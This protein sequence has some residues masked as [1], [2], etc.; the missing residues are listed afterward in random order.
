[1]LRDFVEALVPLR[2][3]EFERAIAGPAERVG[4]RFEPGLLTELV[5]DVSDE[6][7]AL[8]LLQYALTELYERREGTTL[9]RDAYRAIGGVSGALAGRAEEIYGGLGEQA[10]EAGRQLFLRLVTLGEGAEDTRRRVERA[11]LVSME[12]DQDALADAIQ[13]FG[14]WRLLSFDRD[15]RTGT[16]TVEVAHEALMREWGRFRR[17]VDSGREE[18]RLHRRLA[19]AAREWQEAQR[20]PSYLLRGSNLAQFEPL[21]G[22]ATIALTGLEREFVDASR[23]ANELELARQRRQNRRLRMLLAGAVV[24]LVLAVVAGGLALVSRSNAQHEARVALGRQL[25][26]EAVSEPRIDLATLLARESLN[27][28]R[29]F[30]TK[31]TLLAT[32]LRTPAVIGTFT[33]PIQDRPLDVKVSPDGRS[34]AAITNNNVMRIYDTRSHGQTGKFDAVNGGYAY[35]PNSGALLVGDPG[36]VPELLLK[37][38]RTGRTLRKFGL[39]KK[40]QTTLSSQVEP[41]LVTRNGRYGFLLWAVVNQDQSN[42]PAYAEVWRLDRSGPSHLVRLG[43]T[44][45]NAATALS[46]DRLIVA[47]DGQIS[48]LNA[49]TLQRISAV[50]GPTFGPNGCGNCVIS[51]DGR[52]FAYGLANGTVHFVNIATGKSVAGLQGHAAQVLRMAFSPDSRRVVSTGDDGIAILWNP[53]TGQPI[54]RLTGHS[55]RVIGADFGPDGTTLYT[56]GLDGTILEYDLG[57]TRRF[58]SPFTVPP[59]H[60]PFPQAA[61]PPAPLLAISGTSR[62]FAAGALPNNLTQSSV[63]LYSVSA[64]RR[65]GTIALGPDRN[66]S[67]GAWAGSRFVLGADRGLVQLWNVTGRKPLPGQALH[68]LSPKSQLRALATA[69]GGRLVAAVDGWFGP[70]K[71][72]PP[73]HEGELAIWRD[74]RLVSKPMKLVALGNAVALSRDG[75]TAAVAPDDGRALIVDTR[76]GHVERTITPKNA[77]GSVTALAFAPDGTLATGT[78]SGIVNLWNPKT[79]QGIGHPTLVAPAPVASIS[80]S[81]DGQTFATSGGSSGGTRIWVTATQQ[82]LGSDFPGGEGEWG[83]VAYTP[84]GHY[85]FAVF[86]DGR[87]YRWPVSLPAWESQACAVAGR[88]LTREEWRRVVGGRSYSRVCPHFPSG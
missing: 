82:Q 60:P 9:T 72:G 52:T 71:N 51:P 34:I 5:A 84:D 40:W 16:P 3:E 62:L 19:S 30:Q 13:A 25:G 2:A 18:V 64:L 63:E 48:T 10:Q 46:G 80:F 81:P 26:A 66:V 76:T 36:P 24:L 87:G 15:P 50:H 74:G 61:L 12:V 27:L 11:E 70:P 58:G 32:L 8:P 86:G 88:N 4:A 42:G 45:M 47:T 57:G 75:S 78:W 17:W 54:E 38:P 33:V 44:G 73:P 14:T 6:P 7:G 55:G 59:G 68:G 28:D 37:D 21:A 79:G 1:M 67:A 39:S 20:E 49:K 23:T 35:V 69:T 83:T 85:L 31:G 65:V 22:E 56:A 43:G 53:A 77:S 41:I 29:S